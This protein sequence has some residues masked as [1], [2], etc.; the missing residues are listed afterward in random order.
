MKSHIYC[1]LRLPINK[2]DLDGVLV[3]QGRNFKN[4]AIFY[5][6]QFFCIDWRKRGVRRKISALKTSRNRIDKPFFECYF[7]SVFIVGNRRTSR[8]AAE[9]VSSIVILSIPKPMPPV[10]GIPI[11]SALRKS[12]SVVLAS[13]SP[14]ASCS[15]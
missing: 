14:C 11:S 13:S 5:A 1:S 2:K 3:H 12:S 15:S 6:V 10:G 7:S 9:S 8:I 4:Y